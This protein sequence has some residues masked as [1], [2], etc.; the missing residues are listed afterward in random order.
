[1]IIEDASL[2]KTIFIYV[3]KTALSVKQLLNKKLLEKILISKNIVILSHFPILE[4]LRKSF[5]SR[6]VFHTLDDQFENKIKKRI[7]FRLLNYF[8]QFLY[9]RNFKNNT[10]EDFNNIF[11]KEKK[12]SFNMPFFY[13]FYLFIWGG[14][15]YFIGNYKVLRDL[16]MVFDKILHSKNQIDKLIK[17]YEPTCLLTSSP[18]YLDYDFSV[19]NNFKKY[20]LNTVSLLL[21]WDHASGMGLV[22]VKTDYYVVWGNNSKKDLI[23]YNDIDENKIIISGPLHWDFHFNSNLV[24]KKNNFFLK[25]NFNINSKLILISLKSPTRTNIEDIINFLNFLGSFKNKFNCQF[26]IKPHPINYANLYKDDLFQIEKFVKNNNKFFLA[27]KFDEVTNQLSP[28]NLIS[29]KN[30]YIEDLLVNSNKED[31]YVVNLLKNSDLMI[32]FFSTL[33]IEAGIHDLPTINYIFESHNLNYLKSNNRK[34][35]Y[36]DYNQTHNYRLIKTGGSDVCDNK[37]DLVNLIDKYLQN[38]KYK[39]SER[40]KMVFNEINSYDKVLYSNLIDLL[41]KL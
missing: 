29:K 31:A 11:L 37:K 41:K 23:D 9:N 16:F 12:K 21:S 38:R 28:K 13:Y 2:K 1:M 22:R 39:Q 30:G 6:I 14:L 35:L 4:N 25:N 8:R 17:K 15:R 36:L 19:I 20:K 32:N 10:I 34:N 18:G 33:N 27:K 3:S 26:L 7:S 24:E 40:K 5:D